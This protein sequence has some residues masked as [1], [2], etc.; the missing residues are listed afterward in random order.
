MEKVN[1]QIRKLRRRKDGRVVVSEFYHLFWS[2]KGHGS[3]QFSLNA[4]ELQ[5]AEKLKA[6]F[7][8]EKERELTGIMAP[9]QVR[10]AANRLLT[11]HLAD[12]VAYLEGLNR[13]ASHI[14]H[15]N[16]RVRDLAA[17]CA[18]KYLSEIN[19]KAFELWR[20]RNTGNFSIKTL[21]EYRAAMYSMLAWLE[22]NE[23]LP[24]NPFKRV[25]KS[26]G[27]GQEK[28]RRR[29][30]SQSEMEGLLSHAGV[31][32]VAYLAA[33]TTGLRRGEL[34]KL[35]WGDLHLDAVQ[36]VALVRAGTTK[37]RKP[38]KI[39]FGRQLVTE[40]KKLLSPALPSNARVLAGRIPTMK[41]MRE[42]LTAAGIVYVDDQGR[43]LDFHALRKT[44]NTNLGIAGASDAERMKL[45]R[46][47][48]P[49]LMMENYNDS[50]KVPV[51]DVLG[52][53]PEYGGLESGKQYTE[54]HT[55]ILVQSGQ[56]LS[57]PVTNT[58]D[59]NGHKTLANKGECHSLTPLG[60][61]SLKESNGGER[62]I[63]T[64]DTVF[65][66]ITV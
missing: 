55:E 65:G 39:Y 50:E 59:L 48:S 25:K 32:A 4:R 64:P 24:V 29:A 35:E 56:T 2:V 1:V 63:R 3:G 22:E 42:H 18:W 40:L 60:I 53:M 5:A 28:V 6:D 45:A 7:I 17:S 30:A 41:Q 62:G 54:K 21:N 49:R 51:G 66:R 11:E 19:P 12:Y 57:K 16:T 52:K 15:V 14:S 44:F 43:R 8:Y 20:Q 9:R 46:L 38:A 31:Y 13:S 26:D 47:K 58:S 61:P 23:E 37:D 34:S 33:A 10:E 36:P 27:R